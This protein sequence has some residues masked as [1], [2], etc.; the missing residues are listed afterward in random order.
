[1][2]Y[3]RR[4]N[5]KASVDS[6]L[7]DWISVGTNIAYS[8]YRTNGIISGTGS[9]R[10]GVVLSVI[11][12][13]TY[14][15]I[16][17]E[18]NPN[19]YWTNFYGANLTTPAENMART[20]NNYN[21]T[22]RLLMTGYAT[23]KFNRN[24]NFKSTVT[25]D[26]RWTHDYSFLD[27]IHTSYGRTQHGEASSTRADDMRMVY[28]NILTYN[29][30]W[31]GVH[32][33]EAMGGTS[34]TT[35]RWENLSGSR[36]YFSPDYNN[37]IW[38]LNGGNKGGL[39]G[40][41]QGYAE[42]AIMSYLGRVS[43]NYDSK[44]YIT[45]NIRAD[46]SS[47]LAPGHKWGYFPSV[48]AAWR[49]SAEPW[50]QDASWISDLKLRAGW[51][52][53]GNQSGLADNDN[54]AVLNDDGTGAIWLIGAGVGKPSVGPS[55]NT[56]DGAWCCAQVSPKV[57]QITFA[58]GASIALEGADFKFYGEKGWGGEF[59]ADRFSCGEKWLDA[60]EVDPSSGN[61][62][63][64]EPLKSG[65][66]YRLTMDLTAGV[67]NGVLSVEAI[68]SPV[69]TLDITFEGQKASRVSAD[70]YTVA[71]V[72][73]KKGDAVEL[74]G[75]ESMYVDPDYFTGTFG[76]MKFNASDG[77]Y[78]VEIHPLS[79]YM[80]LFRL[81]DDGTEATLSEGALWI[82]GWGIANPVMTNQIGFD[83]KTAYCLAEVEPLVFQFTGTAVEEKDGTTMGGR[84]RYDYISA[85]YF[86]QNAWG[87][88][89]GKIFGTATKVQLEGNCADYL[90]LSDTYNIELAD[91]EA[92][93]LELGATYR[94]TID[95]SK[96][97]S[98][99]IEIVRFDKL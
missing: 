45:A 15:K 54:V 31:N 33:F 59:T 84:F 30:T 56:D 18:E 44:Y 97:Q 26:R 23:I 63:A 43:Y 55:W 38:G 20:E 86:A 28:D 37:V 34:A 1:M 51:G 92:K 58:G 80:E 22:D 41:S 94:L 53:S 91:V 10:A 88:E 67:N 66:Y 39:R 12:T 16:W 36:N 40:Q 82:L 70:M 17:D 9:N 81:K 24:L 27:P 93:P 35:S 72:D 11:N 46:G 87:N 57:Y 96:A 78:R 89:A 21:Q 13:P 50:M 75:V 48:S 42:W 3:N 98:E 64:V 2:A 76:D 90:K 49:I 95:L 68:E 69:S 73:L 85:K 71:S 61:I 8:S 29:N 79:G 4:Y 62:K 52:Q 14:A 65:Q 5:F 6:D 47:K 83:E 77:K 99:G 25:M 74:S 19:W 7:Y 32:N 60:F